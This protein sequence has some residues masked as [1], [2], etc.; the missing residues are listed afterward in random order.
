MDYNPP[1]VSRFPIVNGGR[2]V[3]SESLKQIYVEFD[4]KVN[5][6]SGASCISCPLGCGDCCDHADTEVTNEEATLIAKHIREEEPSLEDHLEKVLADPN[7][8]ECVF[9]DREKDFHC[10]IY[11]VR[12][13]ICRAF[14]YSAYSDRSGNKL[15]AI[16][17]SMPIAKKSGG[18][19]PVLF[20]PYPPVVEEYRDRIE[21]LHAR[22]KR[23]R[24]PLGE[25]VQ[26]AL[27]EIE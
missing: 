22:D 3:N 20:E 4:E 10:R 12:P 24:R 2:L 19:M 7:R 15:F 14:G 16:C 27:K 13:L 1:G 5:E 25:A 9:Y 8:S 17:P 21:N 6:F 23:G 18:V 11:A 26:R